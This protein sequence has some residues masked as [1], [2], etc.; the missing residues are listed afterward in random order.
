MVL[1]VS[2]PGYLRV[3]L[4]K[5]DE[6]APE[7]GYTYD[8]NEFVAEDFDTVHQISDELNYDLFL[9]IKEKEQGVYIKLANPSEDGLS[10][11]TVKATFSPNKFNTTK[12]KPGD[13]GVI[14]YQLLDSTKAELTFTSLVCAPTNKNCNK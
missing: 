10:L 7:L 13:N 1:T 12:P 8:Y 2:N 6:S 9:K 4:S 3:T 14:K 11:M 5:C